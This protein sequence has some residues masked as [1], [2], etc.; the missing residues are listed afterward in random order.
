VDLIP[1][2]KNEVLGKLNLNGYSLLSLDGISNA[3]LGKFSGAFSAQINQ[4]LGID[5]VALT[6]VTES[7][8]TADFGAYF[9]ICMDNDALGRVYLLTLLY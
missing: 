5:K 8:G 3:T 2:F 7:Q 6:K 4:F 9:C 1:G